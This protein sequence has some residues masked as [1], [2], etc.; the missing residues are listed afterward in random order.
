MQDQ[1]L[2]REQAIEKFLQLVRKYGLRWTASVPREAHEQMAE[3]NKVLTEGDRRE[4]LGLR[5]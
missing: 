5:R 2:T 4:A 3:V 1:Q